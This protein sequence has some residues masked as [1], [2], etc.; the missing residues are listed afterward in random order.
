MEGL[1]QKKVPRT[2][3]IY[4]DFLPDMALKSEISKATP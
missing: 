2:N 4:G 3:E 1:G